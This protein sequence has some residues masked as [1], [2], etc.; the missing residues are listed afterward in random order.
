MSFP[1]GRRSVPVLL[2][3][4]APTPEPRSSCDV[5]GPRLPDAATVDALARLQLAARRLGLEI[6]LRHASSELQELLAFV[7]LATTCYE[8]SRAGRP[9]SG[10]S[11][12]VPRKNVSSTIRPSEISSTCSAHG[13]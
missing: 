11:V 6:R 12:S 2:A 10:K 1:R 3:I 4:A 13:S 8:S 7:G 5:G 9:K